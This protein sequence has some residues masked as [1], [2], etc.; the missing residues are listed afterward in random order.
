ML[1]C[2]AQ[3]GQCMVKKRRF[4]GRPRGSSCRL[5]MP[6]SHLH[7]STSKLHYSS[8]WRG[9]QP[10]Y[11]CSKWVCEVWTVLILAQGCKYQVRNCSQWLGLLRYHQQEVFWLS[12][13][14]C[15]LLSEYERS[16]SSISLYYSDFEIEKTT[17]VDKGRVRWLF[18]TCWCICWVKEC[19]LHILS[20]ISMPDSGTGNWG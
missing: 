9:H 8:A 7:P 1:G 14:Q 17:S 6:A 18:C 13:D 16:W 2:S 3:V 10:V 4:N 12:S 20:I 5:G 11:L 15:H 19:M